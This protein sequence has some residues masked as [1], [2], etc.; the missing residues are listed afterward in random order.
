MTSRQVEQ[1]PELIAPAPGCLQLAGLGGQEDPE[2]GL[3]KLVR[4][5][6]RGLR[7]VPSLYEGAKGMMRN[8]T[9]A[10]RRRCRW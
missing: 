8:P 3:A 9:M 6:G 2:V 4:A 10:A 7:L 5:R 1:P